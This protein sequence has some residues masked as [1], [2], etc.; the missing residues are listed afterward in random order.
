MYVIVKELNVLFKQRKIIHFTLDD[1]VLF[2][3]STTPICSFFYF[4][5]SWSTYFMKLSGVCWGGSLGRQQSQPVCV[6]VYAVE[7]LQCSLSPCGVLYG[8]MC[9]KHKRT[10]MHSHTFT[11]Q[12]CTAVC[13]LMQWIYWRSDAEMSRNSLSPF[14]PNE[15]CIL[16]SCIEDIHLVCVQWSLLL[17]LLPL[18]LL[19]N[20]IYYGI[21][22]GGLY[23]SIWYERYI[24]RIYIYIHNDI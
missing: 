10:Y 14:T 2:V 22:V 5:I 19:L 11:R 7:L 16:K 17:L 4:C 15:R 20:I 3:P 21:T 1:I 6:C 18:L 23:E 9:V 13:V 12:H 24:Y 8:C